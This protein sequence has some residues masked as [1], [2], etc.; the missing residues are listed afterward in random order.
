MSK[1][2]IYKIVCDDMPEFIY[3]GSTTNFT[4]RKKSHKNACNNINN[5][6]YNYK[7]Y[8]IIREN[9]G[10]ENWRI[11]IINEC[12]Q[13]LTKTQAHILEEEFRVKLNANLNGQK[14]YTTIEEAKEYNKEYRKGYNERNKETIAERAKKYKENNKQTIKEYNKVWQKEFYENNKEAIAEKSKEKVTCECGCE[15]RKFNLPRHLKTKKHIQL[16]VTIK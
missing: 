3:V 14:C 7:I 8:Q 13:G 2:V 10:W 5:K 4:Q 12:E 9:G 6:S 15:I 11:V 16:M 1:Y